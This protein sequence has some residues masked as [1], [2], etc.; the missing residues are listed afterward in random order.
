MPELEVPPVVDSAP[1]RPGALPRWLL[2]LGPLI[3]LA[4][5]VA[6]FLRVGPVGVFRQTFPPVEELTL[7][8][9]RLP[10]AGLMEV[11]VVNGGAQPVTIA[12]IMVDDANW[13]HSVDGSRTL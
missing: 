5:L 12:Q 9:V 2:G 10:Q 4:A 8:R 7:E 11:R 3:L 6:L 13:V 1:A